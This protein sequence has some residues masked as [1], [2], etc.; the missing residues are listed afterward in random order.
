MKI[1]LSMPRDAMITSTGF[2]HAGYYIARALQNIGHEVP[3]RDPSAPVEFNWAH[4]VYWEW[5][6]STSH[7]IGYTPWESSTVPETWIKPMM[8]ADELWTP[9][10]LIARW[11]EETLDKPV[12][13][14][15]HGVDGGLWRVRHRKPA[16][17]IKFLH[18]GEPA[19]RKGGQLAFDAFRQAF[20]D[21]DK[22]SLTIKAYNYNSIRAEDIRGG[23][24]AGFNNVSLNHRDI[25]DS[26]MVDLV[27]NHDV[28]V[29]PGYGEGFGLIALQAMATGMP[30]ICTSAW[31]PYKKYILPELRLD[32]KIVD[33]PWPQIHP[34]KMFKPDAD[35][36][37]DLYRYAADH[38]EELADKA[39]TRS[40]AVRQRYDWEK[41]TSEAFDPV[42][43]KVTENL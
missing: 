39:F 25:M 28:L 24:P 3:Y 22:V 2:G 33:S 4:P 37:V 10:P 14:Y 13:V 16:D 17:K 34:G 7:H 8:A 30:V 35:H 12:K 40:G 41:L 19:P 20:G 42:V 23:S 6:S 38:I 26:E 31:A 32:S 9:S 15:E 18:I 29:Y 43:K 21:S 5:S 27:R 1:S 36:L 11:F